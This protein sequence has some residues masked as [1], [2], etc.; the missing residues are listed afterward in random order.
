M[1][2][3]LAILKQL[4]LEEKVSLC[5]GLDMWRTKD[6]RRVGVPSIQFADGSSG[7][8]KETSKEDREQYGHSYPSTCFPTA[9]ALACSWNRR[10]LRDVGNAVGKECLNQ[11]VDV[12]LAPGINIKRSPLGGRNFEYFSEDPYLTGKLAKEYVIGVQQNNVA[13]ALKH[14]ALNSQ[15]YY[16]YTVDAIV[17]ERAMREIYLNPFEIVVKEAKPMTIMA[18]YNK[19]NGVYATENKFLLNT[20]LR[21]K[22][23]FNGVTISDWGAVNN[24]IES[25]RAGLNLE[26]P[27]SSG[28]NDRLVM[29]ALQNGRLAIEEVNRSAFNVLKLVFQL[30]DNEAVDYDYQQSHELARKAVVESAVLLKNEDG[31]LPLDENEIINVIG[32]L[33]VEPKYQGNGSSYVSARQLMSFT[34][35]LTQRHARFHY[36]RGYDVNESY[37]DEVLIEE[38]VNTAKNGA[39][40]LLF[41]GLPTKEESEGY[42][43]KQLGLPDNQVE[44]LRRIS[45]VNAKII[46]ILSTGSAV[47]MPWISNVKSVLQ[48]HL[49]GEAIGEGIYDLIFGKENPSGKIAETYPKTLEDSPV[50][51][52]FPMGPKYATY[53]ESIFVGY[54]Y[55]ETAEKEV[56]FPFGHGLSY[57]EFEYGQ[58]TFD[59]NQ[60]AQNDNLTLTFTIQNMSDL[61]ASEVIQIYI[62]PLQSEAVRPK[63]ELKEF[64]KVSL[65]AHEKKRISIRIP[66]TAFSHFNIL[67]RD[68]IV[69]RGYYGIFIG[70]NASEAYIRQDI[71]VEGVKIPKNLEVY[72]PYSNIQTMKFSSEEFS[73]LVTL[74]EIN[75]ELARVG[76]FNLTST[77]SELKNSMLGRLL[78]KYVYDRNYKSLSFVASDEVRKEMS[79]HLTDELPLKNVVMMSGGKIDYKLALSVLE[80]CN[81]KKSGVTLIPQLLK[82]K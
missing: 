26:M 82:L 12:I 20:I 47:A 40:V 78:Y 50:N 52:I 2:D 9:A 33:A 63:R 58:L 69:E 24:R 67:A 81:K 44:L 48:V 3:I 59:K 71:F 53:N 45:E 42:E 61:L 18:S 55:Y 41:L 1:V 57:S 32:R 16:R 10:L 60:L 23:K 25:L 80:V 4:T 15:E 62:Q 74:P 49:A 75:N 27:S 6:I 19:V 31:M 70:K 5:S 68:F 38:A 11:E 36:E 37:I 14:Y 34:D 43:R 51:S 8:R 66:Y 77:I 28:I 65:K 46:V 21:K 30:K 73:H 13:V 56:L 54:R 29:N 72:N 64:A 39:K 22:W 76:Q 17:D 79:I 7:V 35:T